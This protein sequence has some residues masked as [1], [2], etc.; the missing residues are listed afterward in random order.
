MIDRFIAVIDSGIGGI[1][2]LKMMVKELP[3]KNYIYLGDTVNAP[4]GN[5]S[6]RNLLEI[7]MKN[8]DRLKRYELEAIVLGCNTLSVNL[9]GDIAAYSEVPVFGV[10]P[11]IERSMVVGEKTLLLS[12]CA[13]AKKYSG[14][15]VDV[16]G[17][18]NLASDVERHAFSLE[19]IDL[20]NNIKNSEGKFVNEKGY[21]DTIILGC[22]H[23]NLIE[24]QIFNYF[25]PLKT[26][27]GIPYTIGAL[28]G[29]LSKYE[30]YKIAS[31]SQVIFFGK[32]KDINKKIYNKVVNASP[33]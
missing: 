10:F 12:T 32:A 4:Y 1:S 24:N 3:H 26:I 33:F 9:I 13:T 23:Y 16:I 18:K 22:T 30:K 17:F 11:P 20:I 2:L 15:D 28:K 6:I 21:Y 31:K 27:S 29:W 5:K 14:Q 7:T 25:Q 8:I 19:K